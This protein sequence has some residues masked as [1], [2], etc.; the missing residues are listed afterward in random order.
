MYGSSA[1]AQP[2]R[3]WEGESICEVYKSGNLPV[4]GTWNE[5]SRSRVIDC[6]EREFEGNIESFTICVSLYHNGGRFFY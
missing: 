6:T 5:D 4:V 3:N 1:K 2:L